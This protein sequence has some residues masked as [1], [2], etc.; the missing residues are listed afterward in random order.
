MQAVSDS[1][2]VGSA[3][4]GFSTFLSSLNKQSRHGLTL[5]A[6]ARAPFES[7]LAKI[8]EASTSHM[9]QNRATHLL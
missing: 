7:L 5:W 1:V 2:T 6:K 4:C 8:S 3:S 9:W